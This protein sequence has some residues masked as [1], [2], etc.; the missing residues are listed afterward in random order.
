MYPDLIKNRAIVHYKY[1][2]KSI[3][4]VSACYKIGKSTLSRWLKKDGI[5]INRKKKTS[6]LEKINPL[7][8]DLLATNPFLTTKMLSKELYKALN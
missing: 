6:V 5:E 4:K 2:L 8:A 7:V 1:F 3:R